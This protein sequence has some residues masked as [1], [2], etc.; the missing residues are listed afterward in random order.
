MN[1][2]EID[3]LWDVLYYSLFVLVIWFMTGMFRDD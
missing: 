3:M 2:D 1:W